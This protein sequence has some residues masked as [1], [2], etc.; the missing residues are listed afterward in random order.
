MIYN[1]SEKFWYDKLNTCTLI[2]LTKK[3]EGCNN[4]LI[5]IYHDEYH[6]ISGWEIECLECDNEQDPEIYDNIDLL[7]NCYDVDTLNQKESFLRGIIGVKDSII[8]T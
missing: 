4:N 2:T 8:N 5:A 6:Y 1:K 3:C 7:L